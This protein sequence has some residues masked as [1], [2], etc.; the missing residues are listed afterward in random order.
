M[1]CVLVF[2]ML[3]KA[4]MESLAEEE[5]LR[6]VRGTGLLGSAPEA[7]FDRFTRVAAALA[8]TPVALITLMDADRQWLKS[9]VG[10][11]TTE[12]ARDITFCDHAIRTPDVMVVLDAA[13]DDRFANNPL[14]TDPPHVRFYAGAPLVL[15]D[16]HRI[17]TICVLDV[18]PRDSFDERARSALADLA[19][20]VV[21]E[22]ESDQTASAREIA[23]QELQHRLAN[24]FAQ[25]VGLISLTA[26]SDQSKSDYVGELRRRILALNDVHRRL[27]EGGWEPADLEPVLEAAIL[28]A[29]AGRR[30][31]VALDGPH[32]RINARAVMAISL[33][34]FELATN[35][36]KHGAIKTGAD[37]PRVTWR[38][39][40][41]TFEIVWVEPTRRGELR[42]AVAK[43]GFGSTLLRR[44]VPAELSGTATLSFAAGVVRYTL[45]APLGAVT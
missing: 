28:P 7:R 5:R 11:S 19:D 13:S 22:I 9:C 39:T 44:V 31:R 15:R 21:A 41:D 16:G 34:M 24:M 8:N 29:I 12:M 45:T 26:A 1:L 14:V 17:G 38:T 32:L 3:R 42:Q 27:A 2:G 43:K 25:V 36:V 4:V 35:S 10:V 18:Q 23:V 30:E 40:G 6:A 20:L 37:A 33:A